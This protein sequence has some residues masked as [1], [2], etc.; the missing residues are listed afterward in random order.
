MWEDSR[1]FLNRMKIGAPTPPITSRTPKKILI[2][3]ANSGFLGHKTIAENYAALLKKNGNN[4]GLADIF[5]IDRK[6]EVIAGKWAY[7]W[8]LQKLPWLWRWLYQYWHTLPASNWLRTSILPRR[9]EKSQQLILTFKPDIVVT[10][11]P[12]ATSIVNFLKVRRKIPTKIFTVFSDWHTQKFWVFPH[13][14]RY[15]VATQRQRE[16]LL[17]LGFQ[18]RHIVVSGILLSDNFYKAESKQK[19]RTLLHLPQNVPVIL[20]MGGGMGWGIERI[21]D[22]LLNLP[23][24]AEIIVLAGNAAREEKIRRY[25]KSKAVNTGHFRVKG[26]VDPSTYFSAADLLISKPGGMTTSQAFLLRL[27]MLSVYPLPGQEDMNLEVLLDSNAVL[28][29]QKKSNLLTQIISLLADQ[30]SLERVSKAALC[31]APSYARE[32]I[33]ETIIGDSSNI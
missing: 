28:S 7:F 25:L 19:A 13:V 16:D 26:F 9:F 32:K 24:P 10:T 15:F 18:D 4:V 31:L 5:E 11:H 14:D 6:A 30:H 23:S 1:R 29:P 27:P 33:M 17:R 21:V 12:T 3:Y 22:E 2:L 8:L 20:I